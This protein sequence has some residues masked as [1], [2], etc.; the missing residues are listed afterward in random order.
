MTDEVARRL[1]LRLFRTVHRERLEVQEGARRWVFGP[2]DAELRAEVRVHNPRAWRHALRGSVGVAETH[3]NGDW[4]ADDLVALF[5]IGARN[6]GRVDD[7]R[8]RLHPLLHAGQRLG[9]LI[10]HNDLAGSR[11]NVSAHYDLGNQLFSLFLDP[12]MMYSC[13]LFDFPRQSLEEAQLAKLE[14]ICR[15]LRLGPDDHLLE[16][17]TGWGGMAVHAASR[18]GCRVTT[19]TISGE[20]RDYAA[21]RVQAAGLEDRVSVLHQDYRD[22]A[23]TFSKLVSI[24]MVEAVG[25]QYFDAYFARCS[26]LLEPDGLMLL[27]AITIDD[28]AF[29]VEKASKSFINTHIFP[30]GCLPSLEVVHDCIARRTDM[31]TVWLDDITA[32]YAETLGR[33]RRA[34]ANSEALATDLGYDKRFRRMWT[35]YLA[36]VEAGFSECRIGDVQMLL[37]KPEWRGTLPEAKAVERQAMV[38]TG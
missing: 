11:R 2:E 8:R 1:V 6:M 37:A 12:T 25:W 33:W 18:Y 19:T 32:H 5:R 35:L 36:Y 26:E 21:K 16:I 34:F 17:G 7:A 23:G 28:R 4:E 15:R 30:G 31:R 13:A 9:R 24:E 22:L 38:P 3:M 10:P 29:E 14:R 20:Q 27:Q